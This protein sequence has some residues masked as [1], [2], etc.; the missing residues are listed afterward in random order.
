MIEQNP[1]VVPQSKETIM[2]SKILKALNDVFVEEVLTLSYSEK[3][4]VRNIQLAIHLKI[5]EVLMEEIGS[6]KQ[7]LSQKSPTGKGECNG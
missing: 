5:S 3:L 1:R 4:I 7:E 2:I 6:I